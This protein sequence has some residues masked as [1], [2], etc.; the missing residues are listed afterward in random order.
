MH[1][2]Q[3][4]AIDAARA[5]GNILLKRLDRVTPGRT[6]PVAVAEFTVTTNHLLA[7]A[8]TQVIHRAH[9]GH[10]II[11]AGAD[12]P[13][14]TAQL[15]DHRWLVAA[16][17]NAVNYLHNFPQIAVSI[18]FQQRDRLQH[19]V[20]IDP[21]RQEWFTTS[22]GCGAQLNGHRIRASGCRSLAEAL[23]A[24]HC[25]RPS[26]GNDASVRYARTLECLLPDTAGIRQSGAIA[27][28]LAYV[29]AGRLDGLWCW[30]Y[31]AAQPPLAAGTLLVQEAGGLI[32]VSSD[33]HS[34]LDSDE[35]VSGS[36]HISQAML[37]RLRTQRVADLQ[38]VA[39]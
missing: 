23:I 28:D 4:I 2:L 10:A 14:P 15:G 21:L 22:R 35:L 16:L 30:G 17:D 31:Q 36:S 9:P 7:R 3:R 8:V 33:P 26:V 34:G 32:T 11:I 1:P 39:K 27:L 38:A 19:A 18:A 37:Q 20:V 6:N 29:A 12:S 5:A 13:Q 24:C 25:A